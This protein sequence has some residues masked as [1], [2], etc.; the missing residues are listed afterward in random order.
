MASSSTNTPNDGAQ[1]P[2]KPPNKTD[3]KLPTIAPVSKETIAQQHDKYI[4]QF[5]EGKYH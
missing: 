5:S 2:P 3:K 1:Q 4:T